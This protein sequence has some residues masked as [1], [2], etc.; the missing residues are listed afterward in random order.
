MNRIESVLSTWRFSLYVLLLIKVMYTSPLRIK[1]KVYPYVFRQQY[2]QKQCYLT[3]RI[4][5]VKIYSTQGA[6]NFS[7]LVARV[8]NNWGNGRLWEFVPQRVGRGNHILVLQVCQH[9]MWAALV[10]F[11]PEQHISACRDLA[12]PPFCFVA[13]CLPLPQPC[14][15]V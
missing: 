14:L 10:T 1:I 15:W 6:S 3:F 7:H 12:F 13:L 11:P 5:L 8:Q 2:T 9:S 4:S